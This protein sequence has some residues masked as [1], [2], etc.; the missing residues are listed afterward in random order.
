M[1]SAMETIKGWLCSY[2]TISIVVLEQYC[3][4]VWGAYVFGFVF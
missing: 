3:V 4:N 1:F 2:Y